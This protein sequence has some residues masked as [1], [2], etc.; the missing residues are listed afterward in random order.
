MK[1]H[2]I[3]VTEAL[4]ECDDIVIAP[5]ISKTA[6][7][8]AV[9]RD[10]VRRLTAALNH[11]VEVTERAFEAMNENADRGEEAEADAKRYRWLRTAK[12]ADVRLVGIGQRAG[13]YLDAA[14]DEAMKYD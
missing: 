2:D 11:Q 14:I 4:L 12:R 13:T 10:E 3:S 1:Q 6:Q 5:G 8:A 9:L 7:A